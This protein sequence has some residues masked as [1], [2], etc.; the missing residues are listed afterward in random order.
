MDTPNALISVIVPSYRSRHAIP[1]CLE[2]LRRQER[3]GS[4][5]VIVA[6][7]SDDG[8]ADV[9]AQRFPEAKV[10]RSAKRLAPGAARNLAI[11]RAVGE[12]LAFT[13]ADCV[14]SP[15]WIL[16]I[17]KAH[18]APVPAIGGVIASG[19]PE[20]YVGWAYYF[21]KLSRWM[22]G[23]KSSHMD[24]V[25]TGCLSIKR[26]A[27]EQFGP[28]RE[29]GFSSD[30]DFCWKLGRAGHAVLFVPSIRVAHVNIEQLGEFCRKL[31]V[32]GRAFARM[33]ARQRDFSWPRRWL[34]AL[35][36]PLL[37]VVLFGRTLRR[38]VESGAYVREFRRAAPLVLFGYALWS[39]G[40][41]RGNLDSAA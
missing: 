5:E 25:P 20:S 19:N 13:D 3:P 4:Y 35:L 21:C 30:T 16:E 26:W 33:R 11:R 7:S 23:M 37:T 38:V 12:I 31:Y 2:A 9:I 22:P 24:E 29:T 17:R 8:T 10:L 15:D 14:P 6:D 40:E 39:V 1:R 36:S 41:L 34:Y 27:V 32:H 28:F 18:R